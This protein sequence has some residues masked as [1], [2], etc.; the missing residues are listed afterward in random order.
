M[1]SRYFM[2][3]IVAFGYAFLY[4]PVMLLVIYS[5]NES[6]LVTVW[7]GFSTR[8]YGSLFS[9]D[10]LLS[11]AWL[12]LRIAMVNATFAVMLG[13]LAAWSLTRFRRFRGRTS[14][15]MLLTAP[16]TTQPP[17]RECSAPQYSAQNSR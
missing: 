14:F 2:I 12:S 5:F 16:S 4:V 1:K 6:R 3:A 15:E 11:A 13:T 10:S 8:W 17:M 7:G 9:N